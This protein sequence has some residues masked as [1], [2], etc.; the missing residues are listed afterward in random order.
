MLIELEPRRSTVSTKTIIAAAVVAVFI[1]PAPDSAK[2]LTGHLQATS[3]AF[4]AVTKPLR[5]ARPAQRSGGAQT[6]AQQVLGLDGRVVGTD[7]D[8]GVRFQLRR[9]GGMERGSGGAGGGGGGS[10]GGGGG[11]M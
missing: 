8:A 10:G 2:A 3:G 6:R 7:P 4:A 11:G 1:A 5:T 9:D